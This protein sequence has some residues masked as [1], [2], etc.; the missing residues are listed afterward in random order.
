[1]IEIMNEVYNWDEIDEATDEEYQVVKD[2]YQKFKD[3]I[4]L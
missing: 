1:M 3:N 2:T 4:E